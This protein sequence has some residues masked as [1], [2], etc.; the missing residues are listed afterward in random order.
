VVIGPVS[1]PEPRKIDD[2]LVA[3]MV[4]CLTTTAGLELDF[5]SALA[6]K[7]FDL[8]VSRVRKSLKLERYARRQGRKLDD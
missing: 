5:A 4:G 6:A 1:S 2:G 3:R 7:A 8:P